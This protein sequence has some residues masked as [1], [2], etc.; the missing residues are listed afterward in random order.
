MKQTAQRSHGFHMP[1]GVQGQAG[2]GPEKPALVSD[3][4]GGSACGRGMGT[5]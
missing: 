2:W 4:V 3:V 1:R 5:R